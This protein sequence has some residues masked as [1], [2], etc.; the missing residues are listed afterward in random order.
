MP[1]L[2][3]CNHSDGRLSIPRDIR[4]EFLSCPVHGPEWRE[5]L[6]KFDREWAA[7]NAAE[8]TP[9]TAPRLENVMCFS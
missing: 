1:E 4:S 9:N 6:T 5:L 3:L 7:P 2:V 8:S